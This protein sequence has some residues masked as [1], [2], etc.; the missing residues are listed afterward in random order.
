M[1]TGEEGGPGVI[2][3]FALKGG[4]IVTSPNTCTCF[5]SLEPRVVKYVASCGKEMT[6]LRVGSRLFDVRA[7]TPMLFTGERQPEHDMGTM[8]Q[9][10]TLHGLGW[11]PEK[12]L[13]LG[14]FLNGVILFSHRT[15]K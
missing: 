7:Y 11:I 5:G 4:E 15:E 1:G 14:H 9:F 12:S 3:P 2:V 6:T 8:Y 13:E 10:L